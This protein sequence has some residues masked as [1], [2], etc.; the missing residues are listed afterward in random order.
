MF[1]YW[2]FPKPE[3]RKSLSRNPPFRSKFHT[4]CVFFS[5]RCFCQR[6]STLQ[7]S[8]A[9][10]NFLSPGGQYGKGSKA[11]YRALST[12]DSELRGKR[13]VAWFV[14]GGGAHWRERESV[15]ESG[16]YPL[17]SLFLTMKSIM[18]LSVSTDS[19]CTKSREAPTPYASN[20][21]YCTKSRQRIQIPTHGGIS[22]IKTF[23]R[24]SLP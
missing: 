23:G 20:Y 19:I 17:E 2:R 1:P 15:R 8:L 24:C 6:P 4:K 21:M 7:E 14:E 11:E 12:N 16:E 3:R 22:E 18:G 9:R 5:N 10:L 13:F